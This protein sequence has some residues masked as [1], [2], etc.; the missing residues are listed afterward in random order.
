MVQLFV[1]APCSTFALEVASGACVADV[2]DAVESMTGMSG[3][4]LA[5]GSSILTEATLECLEEESTINV[6]VPLDGGAKKRKKKAVGKTSK[7]KQ[8]RKPNP[9][10][11]LKY[12]E[13]SGEGEIRRLRSD[14]QHCGA[15]VR[16]SRH[17]QGSTTRLYCGRCHHTLKQEQ[18]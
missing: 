10:A 16:Y 9:L 17:S 3:F 4:V 18:E 5:T 15:G 12:F 2:T 11:V 1:R 7:V 14:C 6:V 13:V 8:V